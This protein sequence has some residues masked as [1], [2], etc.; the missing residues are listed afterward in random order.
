MEKAKPKK[1][2]WKYNFYIDSDIKSWE[3]LNLY[4]QNGFMFQ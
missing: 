2:Q 3:S 4:I 1:K